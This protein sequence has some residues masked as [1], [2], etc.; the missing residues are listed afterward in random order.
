MTVMIHIIQESILF[1]FPGKSDGA[2]VINYCIILCAKQF[3]YLEKLNDNKEQN[4]LNIDLLGYLSQLKYKLK[5]KK[6]KHMNSL[7]SKY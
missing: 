6:E 5:I 1:G 4:V 3:I 2:I 7:K